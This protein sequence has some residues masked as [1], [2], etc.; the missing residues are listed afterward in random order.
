[1]AIAC[2][3]WAVPAQADLLFYILGDHPEGIQQGDGSY[4]LRLDT[5]GTSELQTF[6]FTNVSG[7]IDTSTGVFSILGS[8]THNQSGTVYSI[9]SEIW[10]DPVGSV[11]PLSAAAVDEL[12]SLTPNIDLAGNTVSMSLTGDPEA[13]IPVTEWEGIGG[14]PTFHI[15]SDYEHLDDTFT[16]GFTGVGWLTPFGGGGEGHENSQDWLF[17]M[18][19]VPGGGPGTNT[20]TNEVPEPATLGLL[21]IGLLG[22]ATRLRTRKIA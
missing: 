14:P 10:L 11:E 9:A 2:A 17:T 12:T 13:G 7:V 1:M 18:T 20:N 4:G 15:A 6:S 16:P 8:I 5:P 21:G 3:F 19:Y 22:L